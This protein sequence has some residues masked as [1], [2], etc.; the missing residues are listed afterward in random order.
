MCNRRNRGGPDAGKRL[1]AVGAC[2]APTPT[3]SVCSGARTRFGSRRALAFP[4]R[5]SSGA[6]ALAPNSVLRDRGFLFYLCS[7]TVS[8]LAIQMQGVAVGWQVYELTGS[9]LDLGLIGLAQFAPFVVLILPAGHAA[10]RYDRKRLILAC[11]ALQLVCAAFLLAFSLSGST[12]VWPIFS[13]LVLQGIARAFSMP[14]SQAFLTNI[15]SQQA[16]GRAV[17]LASS[18]FH[19]AVILGPTLGGALYVAGPSWVY[20]IVCCALAISVLLLIPV[21][22]IVEPSKKEPSSLSGALEGLRFVWS[23]P[24][25]LGALSLD[26]F[27]V[28]LGGAVALLPAYAR[29]VLHVDSTG[30]GLLRTAPGLGAALTS[31]FLAIH[32]IG[33][34]VGH[35]MFGG[36]AVYGLSNVVLGLTDQFGVALAMLAIGGAGDMVSV[37][38]RHIL[39]QSETPDTLRGRVSAVNSVFIGASNELGEFESGITAAWLGLVPAIITGGCLTLFVAVVWSLRFKVLTFMDRFPHESKTLG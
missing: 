1:P 37:Y 26:L 36:V 10:D 3:S 16:F 39:V 38:V 31:G 33:R 7:R 22:S 4:G 34:K 5:L 9:L 35:W 32:P 13:A 8:A 19:V 6:R 20:S 29:D 28:L 17:A 27:A 23:R 14:A 11:F 24:V 2:A 21:R 12:S 25:I 30:L 15:V 18:T